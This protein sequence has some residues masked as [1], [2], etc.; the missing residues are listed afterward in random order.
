M[1]DCTPQRRLREIPGL[2]EFP[3]SCEQPPV[4]K[5]LHTDGCTF[6]F[7]LTEVPVGSATPSLSVDLHRGS[8]TIPFYRTVGPGIYSRLLPVGGI[9]YRLRLPVN[10]P[11]WHD[12]YYTA[13]I[14]V[15]GVV[16]PAQPILYR[17]CEGCTDCEPFIP[18]ASGAPAI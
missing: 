6:D 4:V 17:Q 14:R 8:D 13:K 10:D 16:Q 9:Q 3:T 7:A 18:Q 2:G 5:A 1:N 15:N 12:G 11:R